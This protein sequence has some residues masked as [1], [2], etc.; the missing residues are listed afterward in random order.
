MKLNE[1]VTAIRKLWS[2][3]SKNTS[4][5]TNIKIRKDKKENIGFVNQYTLHEFIPNKWF[6]WEKRVN[7]EIMVIG[8]DWGPYSALLSYIEKYKVEKD[9]PN[10]NYDEFLFNT[11]SSRTEK[12]IVKVVESSHDSTYKKPISTKVWNNF[13][14][15]LAVLFTRQGKHFR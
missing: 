2:D 7:S 10:F 11:F 8:Q 3:L 14:F 15:T 13:F 6:D 9:L 1:K 12:F 5:L 4:C